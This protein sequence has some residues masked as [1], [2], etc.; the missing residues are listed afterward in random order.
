[1]SLENIFHMALVVMCFI[2]MHTQT[3]SRGQAESDTQ[4][5]MAEV[6]ISILK[7]LLSHWIHTHRKTKNKTYFI[8]A[9]FEFS[10]EDF[11]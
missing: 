3:S 1:M 11:L 4:E 10:S 9:S 7:P 5:S 6:S 8:N 2:N